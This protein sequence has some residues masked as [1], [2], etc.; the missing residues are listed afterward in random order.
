MTVCERYLQLSK[1]ELQTLKEVKEFFTDIKEYLKIL[2]DHHKLISAE[3]KRVYLS[4]EAFEIGEEDKSDKHGIHFLVEYNN[5]CHC[6]PEYCQR[7]L[8]ISSDELQLSLDEY[9]NKLAQ[10]KQIEI[11]KQKQIDQMRIKEEKRKSEEK[12]RELLAKL[13]AKYDI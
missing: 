3:V 8:V 10:D 1:Q 2:L 13:K 6:H 4:R 7:V 11:E 9:K 5:A 12:E